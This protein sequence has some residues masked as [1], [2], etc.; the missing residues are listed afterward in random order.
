MLTNNKPQTLVRMVMPNAAI[1]QAVL[2]DMPASLTLQTPF[3]AMQVEVGQKFS[4]DR[5]RLTKA[6]RGVQL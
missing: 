6:R 1:V 5:N 3:G 2:T 4:D